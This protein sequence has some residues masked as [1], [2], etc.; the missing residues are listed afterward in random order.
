MLSQCNLSYKLRYDTLKVTPFWLYVVS[1]PLALP[2]SHTSSLTPHLIIFTLVHKNL[3]EE[4]SSVPVCLCKVTFLHALPQSSHH[5]CWPIPLIIH[6]RVPSPP[7]Y[8]QSTT[9][10]N[11]KLFPEIYWNDTVVI[12]PIVLVPRLRTTHLLSRPHFLVPHPTPTW[13]LPIPSR[14]TINHHTKHNSITLHNYFTTNHR[15]TP[16]T[17]EPWPRTKGSC[18]HPVTLGCQPSSFPISSDVHFVVVFHSQTYAPLHSHLYSHCF[19]Q[20]FSSL[21]IV[22]TPTVF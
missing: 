11:Y 18:L 19:L 20:R 3:S 1:K 17:S 2:L 13:L 8:H 14:K 21:Y 12:L 22:V 6:T 9:L 16:F 7:T 10:R 15:H 5:T 4:M